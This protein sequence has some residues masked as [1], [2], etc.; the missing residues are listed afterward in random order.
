MKTTKI[1][2]AG[3]IA[4]LFLWAVTSQAT[5]TLTS[6]TTS[7]SVG[8]DVALD[9]SG[10][11]IT[12]LVTPFTSIPGSAF[13]GVLTTTVLQESAAF[14]PLGG[15]TFEYTLANAGPDSLSRLTLTGWAGLGTLVA[16]NTGSGTVAN[17][18]DHATANL[19]GFSWVNPPG[20]PSAGYATVFIRTGATQFAS[21]TATVLDGGMASFTALGAGG[22]SGGVFA[23]PEPITIFSGA[24][25]ILPLGVSTMRFLRH[26]NWV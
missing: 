15:Y 1:L 7:G 26:K 12:T 25:M 4:G 10:L 2:R 13:S 16:G 9:S 22:A 17:T 5:L 6:G 19:I 18:A 20:I 8:G 11:V 21:D 3:A 24:L 14:N 23:V